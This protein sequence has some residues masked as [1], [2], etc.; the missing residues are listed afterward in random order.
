MPLK[1]RKSSS[2]PKQKIRDAANTVEL[3]IDRSDVKA[4]T[5]GD[6]TTNLDEG[7]EEKPLG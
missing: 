7:Y 2:P 5:G 6:T 3:S 4:S 1:P